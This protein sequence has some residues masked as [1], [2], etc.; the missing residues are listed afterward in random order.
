MTVPDMEVDAALR[1]PR[2]RVLEDDSEDDFDLDNPEAALFAAETDQLA[3]RLQTRRP[4]RVLDSNHRPEDIMPVYV[5]I[6]RYEGLKR[7]GNLWQ[8]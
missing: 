2:H 4:T 3:V 1:S 7:Q 6:H 8:R 5:T